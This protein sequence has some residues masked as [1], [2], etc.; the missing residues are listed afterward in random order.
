MRQAFVILNPAAGRG[1]AVRVWPTIRP[2]LRSGGL[3]VVEVVAERPMHAWTLAEEA[4]KRGHD[5]IVAV[6]GDGTS[7]EVIN[8]LLRGRPQQ[9]PALAVVPTG[10]ANSLPRALGVPRDPRAAARVL[11][12]GIRRRIDLGQVNDRYFATISGVGFDAEVASKVNQW[13][14]RGFRGPVL[15]I[16]GTLKMLIGYRP[17]EAQISIDGQE[18]TLR[19]FLLAAGNT[20]WYGGWFCMCPHARIDDGQLAV[21]L[22]KDLG[23][24]ETLAVLPKVFSGSHLMHPKVA[25]AS[26]RYV[27]V[28]SAV[29]LAI[30][31]DGESVGHVP[32]TFRAVPQALDVLVPADS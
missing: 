16:V 14:A 20:C 21:V 25:H 13:K 29:P 11:L 5:L 28:E 7:H 19:I 6:G 9:P 30:H 8:G 10:T 4:A 18:Q 27:R 26:A 1:R 22:A 15:Y 17:V 24:M 23:R 3:E 2:A 32:A 12:N 31:A